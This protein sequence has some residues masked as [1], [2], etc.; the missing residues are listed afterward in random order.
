L[1]Q[2]YSV[3]AL[4]LF[5]LIKIKLIGDQTSLGKYKVVKIDDFG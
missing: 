1:L 3:K 2:N 5:E 4:I